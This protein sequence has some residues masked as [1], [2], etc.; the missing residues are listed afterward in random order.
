MTSVN[1]SI[2]TKIGS[3]ILAEDD[4]DD[5]NIF[6]LALREVDENIELD[7]ASNGNELISLLQEKHPDL[8]FLDLEMPY[9]NGLQCLVD[10]R[11]NT[12][13]ESLPVV[14]FSSTTK[15]SNIQTA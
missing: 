12:A 14:V 3:I 5:Q 4:V 9:K 6:Q 15:P 1:H 8:V 13:I 2:L 7:F 11:R 10:I